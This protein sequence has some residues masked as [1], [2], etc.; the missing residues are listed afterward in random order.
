M[1]ILTILQIPQTAQPRLS[2]AD[3]HQVGGC[4]LVRT[5]ACRPARGG[6]R[7][8]GG[9]WHAP[10]PAWPLGEVG[11]GGGTD[12]HWAPEGPTLRRL[13]ARWAGG[14]SLPALPRPHPVPHAIK[15]AISGPPERFRRGRPVGMRISVR[16]AASFG[17]GGR[18]RPS[19]ARCCLLPCVPM[20][21]APAGRAEMGSRRRPKQVAGMA[22]SA[23]RL[24]GAEECYGEPGQW[25]RCIVV[26]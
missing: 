17:P 4:A 5:Q 12:A 13:W 8:D 15:R 14:V 16:S 22:R 23:H 21:P 25:P 20:A 24:G 6:L 7:P 2:I 3:R 18:P 1:Q 26:A 19:H 11:K 10:R 9:P